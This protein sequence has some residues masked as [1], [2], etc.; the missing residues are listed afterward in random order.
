MSLDQTNMELGGKKLHE[1]EPEPEP[2]PAS[3]TRYGVSL[4]G[5]QLLN[6]TVIFII[7][8]H[9]SESYQFPWT[10]I[11]DFRKWV[12]L[13]ESI[14]MVK[15]LK[16]HLLRSLEISFSSSIFKCPHIIILF[17]TYTPQSIYILYKEI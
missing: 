17:S 4:E 15:R 13:C 14:H 2:E 10:A 7:I 5:H 8:F 1:L 16:T 3:P 12:N 11:K 6:M 9:S